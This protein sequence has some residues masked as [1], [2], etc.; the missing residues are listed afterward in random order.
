MSEV[1]CCTIKTRWP[2]FFSIVVGVR[3]VSVKKNRFCQYYPGQNHD[4]REVAAL[5]VPC[6]RRDVP[7]LSGFLKADR[8]AV[9]H[10]FHPIL[11][12]DKC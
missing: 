10:D 3:I 12:V 2:P 4:P 7:I 11:Y 9:E 6:V 1:L 8:S 5:P